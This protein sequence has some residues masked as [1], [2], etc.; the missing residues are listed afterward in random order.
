[1]PSSP[2]LYPTPYRFSDPLST[3]AHADYWLE[4]LAT[5]PTAD[6]SAFTR[7]LAAYR[8]TL[9]CIPF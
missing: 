1:M 8:Q 9:A 6:A 4:C 3:V 2:I 7:L 5:F